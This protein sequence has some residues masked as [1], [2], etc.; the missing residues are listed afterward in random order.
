VAGTAADAADF[1]ASMAGPDASRASGIASRPAASHSRISI[2]DV[3]SR[4]MLLESAR[5]Q[6]SRPSA[7]KS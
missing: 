7:S 6:L 1:K 4:A 3:T 5:Q 2:A